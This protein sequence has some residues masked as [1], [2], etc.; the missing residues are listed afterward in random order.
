M[1]PQRIELE[2]PAEW[3]RWLAESPD[4]YRQ[5]AVQAGGLARATFRLA[6]AR[7]RAHGDA[8][9][10]LRELEAAA[11]LLAARLGMTEGFPVSALLASDCEQQ[12]LVVI[13]PLQPATASNDT[14]VPPLKRAS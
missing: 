6:S 14:P 1:S 12:G 5:L 4:G 10:T 9:P 8:V 13:R 2:R 11:V 7:C 3:L